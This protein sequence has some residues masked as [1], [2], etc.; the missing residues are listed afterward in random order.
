MSD[1]FYMTDDYFYGF[2]VIFYA[3]F[4]FI[5]FLYMLGLL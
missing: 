4:C 2:L 1:E 5:V 3:I